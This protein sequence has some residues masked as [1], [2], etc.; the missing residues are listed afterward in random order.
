MRL[1]QAQARR[2]I[3]AAQ[4]IGRDR[5]R[6][7]GMRQLSST[8]TRLGQFQIDSVNVLA[9]AHLM[10]MYTRFGAYDTS[11]LTRAAEQAPRRLFEFWG[12]AASLIDVELYPALQFRREAA[13]AETWGQMRALIDAHP[14]I[15]DT[16][17]AMVRERGPATAR[18]LDLGE[19]R[20]KDNWGWNWS[21]AKT[22]LEWLYWCGRVTVAGRNTQFERVY[23]LPERVI[24]QSSLD[25]AACWIDAPPAT[26]DALTRQAHVTL[27]RR[28]AQALGVA[29]ARCLRD[30]FRTAQAPTK[31][32]ITELVRTGELLPVEVDDLNEATWI[33]HEARRPRTI[34]ATTL[35]S[36][37]DSLIFE[38][39]RL[40]GFF[41]IDYTI[42][43]Y[44]PKEQRTHG[45]YVYLLLI[46]ETYA[47]R[48]D[49]KADR[50]TGTLV[51]QSAWLEPDSGL[52]HSRV[53]SELAAE[54][55]R[56]ADWLGLPDIHV[57]GKG[58]LAPD[59][60]RHLVVGQ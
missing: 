31:A 15:A 44:T 39:K 5:D 43:I 58:D 34:K 25:A 51:I 10:P 24:P 22:A 4:G 50:A 46:D 11:L 33:W 56:L 1:T 52:P 8:I 55:R 54:L 45:Y 37:F 59:L 27:V 53:V 2:V 42:G 40:A 29:T 18:D 30:Y 9:R 38:R 20:Q 12:H 14:E 26:H 23:D 57:V 16:M 28:A 36:P 19:Q 7:V 48:V 3:L 35:V 60:A 41:N 49:L 6:P 17:V 47:A 21:M 13:Y 32:A